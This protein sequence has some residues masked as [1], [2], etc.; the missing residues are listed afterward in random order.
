M[1][2]TLF[3][4]L[5]LCAAC[6]STKNLRMEDVV[7]IYQRSLPDW[8]VGSTMELKRDSTFVYKWW[9]GLMFGETNG[10]WEVNRSGVVLNSDFQPT[11]EDSVYYK[12]ESYL[13]GN[14][15]SL[16]INLKDDLEVIPFA[17][18]LVK[19]DTNILFKGQ[20]DLSGNIVVPK[21]VSGKLKFLLLV[22]SL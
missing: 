22:M 19:K 8:G 16:N 1:K 3:T 17:S 4:L 12:V 11:R 9:A 18:C 15:D 14:A 2:F 21:V 20:T 10:T 6:L 7:A 13:L 5:I